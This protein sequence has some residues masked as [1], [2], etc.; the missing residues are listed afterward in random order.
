MPF[1][2]QEEQ[3]LKQLVGKAQILVTVCNNAATVLSEEFQDMITGPAGEVQALL[4]QIQVQPTTWDHEFHREDCDIEYFTPD[5]PE[6]ERVGREDTGVK[7]THRPTGLSV[8]S[9]S[10][11]DRAENEKRAQRALGDMVT[12]RF[13]K[14][15]TDPLR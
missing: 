10:S 4:Q 8:R 9:Y 14:P 3:L 2:A 15:R 6:S 12:R 5:V 1:S 7:L 13:P 11:R